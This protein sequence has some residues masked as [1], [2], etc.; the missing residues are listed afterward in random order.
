[1]YDVKNQIPEFA[2]I[3]NASKHDIIP[4]KEMNYQSESIYVLDRGYFSIK[5]FKK[6]NENKAFFVTRTK[7]NTKYR[8]IRKMKI[9]DSSVKADIIIDFTDLKMRDYKERLRVVRYYDAVSDKDYEFIT[10]NFDMDAKTIAEIYKA[11]WSVELFFKHIKQNLKIKKFIGNSENAVKIQIWIA[12]ITMLLVE[13]IRF[14]SRTVFSSMEVIRLLGDNIFSSKSI[15][16]ILK[17]VKYRP[18]TTKRINH[19]LQLSLAW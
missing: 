3:T 16:Y 18:L 1:M 17:E 4:A 10:N 2:V 6:I 8:V 12:M 9:E 19:D 13:Y 15:T 5:L 14:L 7:V 11:R